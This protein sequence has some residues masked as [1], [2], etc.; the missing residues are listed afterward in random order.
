MGLEL[1]SMDVLVANID[2]SDFISGFTIVTLVI[3]LLWD[4]RVVI[5][6]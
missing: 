4:K 2:F 1:V 3:L 5:R 6:I